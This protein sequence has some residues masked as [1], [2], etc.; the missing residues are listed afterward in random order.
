MTTPAPSLVDLFLGLPDY[1][2]PLIV[3]FFG[4]I[5]D[6]LSVISGPLMNFVQR[7]LGG[8]LDVLA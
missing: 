5:L 4:I 1:A 7:A 2:D 8:L 3:L 6:V